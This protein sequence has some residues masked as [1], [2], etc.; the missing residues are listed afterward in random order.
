MTRIPEL[1]LEELNSTADKNS[2]IQREAKARNIVFF[3]GLKYALDPSLALSLSKVPTHDN[4]SNKQLP[5]PAFKEG[6]DQLLILQRGETNKYAVNDLLIDLMHRSNAK[7]WNG[8]FRRILLGE[9]QVE[10]TAIDINKIVDEFA[11]EYHISMKRV[12]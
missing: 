4:M 12:I 10:I 8:W 7:Q 3:E 1:I 11:P 5:W 2:I 9:L 6:L